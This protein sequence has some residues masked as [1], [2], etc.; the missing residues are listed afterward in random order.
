MLQKM[1]K[2]LIIAAAPIKDYKPL[3]EYLS[4]IDYII[5]ADGGYKHAGRLHLKPDVIIGDLD[6]IGEIPKDIE[7]LRFNAE[8]DETDTLLAVKLGIEKGCKD[9]IIIGG[10][11]G[12]LDHTYANF[13]TLLYIIRNGCTGFIADSDCEVHIIEN[14]EISFKNRKDYYISVFPFGTE[15]VFVTE[16]GLKYALNRHLVRSDNCIGVS[17]EFKDEFAT[18]IAEEGSIIIIL[19]KK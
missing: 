9:F 14:G 15:T 8:K 7:V 11:G 19:S 10:L 17:N 12:R 3:T 16:I 18:I 5:C 2:C 6:S 1:N 4:N 13:S